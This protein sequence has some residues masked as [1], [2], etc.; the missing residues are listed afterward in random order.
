M[1]L[2]TKLITSFYTKVELDKI[3]LIKFHTVIDVT[4]KAMHASFE[5]S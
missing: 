5:N 1:K 3:L 2:K 4:V